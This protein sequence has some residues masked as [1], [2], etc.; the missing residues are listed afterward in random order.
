MAARNLLVG[1]AVVAVL[2]NQSL[3]LE[4]LDES[5]IQR[6]FEVDSIEK[7]PEHE[8]VYPRVVTE[9]GAFAV[10]G[11]ALSSDTLR[12]TF[13]AFGEDFDLW[14]KRDDFGIAPDFE[15]RVISKEGTRQQ[16]IRTDCLYSG[17]WNMD[18]TSL[19]TAETSDGL[20]V[21]IHGKGGPIYVT[22]LKD[23]PPSNRGLGLAH[24]AYKGSNEIHCATDNT[25]GP[26]RFTSLNS[27]SKP[28]RHASQ[29]VLELAMYS[30]Y[31]LYSKH[32]ADTGMKILRLYAAVAGLLEL[33]SLSSGNLMVKLTS[34]GV[35][36]ILMSCRLQPILTIHWISVQS[37]Q[38]P[39]GKLPVCSSTLTTLLTYQGS[40]YPECTRA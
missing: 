32:G 16:P 31:E 25:M 33:P 17:K 30:D 1:L 14:L 29:K 9:K 2:M 34:G 6:L 4:L 22:P 35:I 23:Q 12:L 19:V 27:A 20:H 21:M 36:M 11:D 39:T 13:Q 37:M 15:M 8:L 38:K 24:V 10:T 3:S 5:A 7:A 28:A 40:T 26:A 18:P